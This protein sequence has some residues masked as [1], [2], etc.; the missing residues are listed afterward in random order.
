VKDTAPLA[1]TWNKAES[2]LLEIDHVTATLAD[3]VPTAVAGATTV[4]E[5]APVMTTGPAMALVLA[6]AT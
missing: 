2:R 6:L 4:A 5:S 3:S 1:E